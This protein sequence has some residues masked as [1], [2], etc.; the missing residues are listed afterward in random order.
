[1]NE[2]NSEFCITVG[3]LIR[4]GPTCWGLGA[5]FLADV[6]H[7]LAELCVIVDVSRD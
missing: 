7:M 4:T 2:K 6:D 5:D 3:P 1:M